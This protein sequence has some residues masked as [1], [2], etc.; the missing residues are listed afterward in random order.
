MGLY[1]RFFREYN[2]VLSLN[3]R[4]SVK[5]L[6]PFV[7]KSKADV[8]TIGSQNGVDF[9]RTWTCYRGGLKP[10]QTCPSC[11]ER[12]LAFNNASVKDPLI[13]KSVDL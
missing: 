13:G 6:A 11:V 3:R 9:S 5:V 12:A 2:N 8:V 7:N 1:G 4:N 10:C